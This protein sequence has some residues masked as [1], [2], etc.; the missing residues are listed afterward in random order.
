M[1]AAMKP[2]VVYA[3]TWSAAGPPMRRIGCCQTWSVTLIASKPAASLPESCRRLLLALSIPENKQV[4]TLTERQR[5]ALA[6][7]VSAPPAE[8]RAQAESQ[9]LAVHAVAAA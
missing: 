4:G 6:A 1:R 8:R 7:M 9:P 2:N 5:G 3:S